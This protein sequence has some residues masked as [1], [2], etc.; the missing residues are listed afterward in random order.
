VQT[1]CAAKP[2]VV[3]VH[4]LAPFR[5]P[6]MFPAIY[7]DEYNPT[8]AVY[9]RAL[10]ASARRS[11]HL[12]L[13]ERRHPHR[14]VARP[15]STR[16]NRWA[17]VCEGAQTLVP[18]VSCMGC[19]S[20]VPRSPDRPD[21][22]DSAATD[23]LLTCRRPAPSRFAVPARGLIS[24]LVSR[25]RASDLSHAP[26][27]GAARLHIG[28]GDDYRN[29]FVNL[30]RGECRADVYHDLNHVPYPFD[31]HTFELIIAN[32]TLEHLSRESWVPIVVE[33]YRISR[34]NAVWEF[35]SPYALSD[36]FATDPTH[37]MALTPRTFDY[38]DPT[39]DLSRFGRIYGMDCDL[40][41][42]TGTLI[43]TDRH[44][45]DVYH[46][47]LVVKAEQVKPQVPPELPAFLY[48]PEPAL[49][50]LRQRMS[51]TRARLTQPTLGG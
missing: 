39:R 26:E 49:Q 48:Q 31:D 43:P 16:W 27:S 44:G 23:G 15:S 3:T 37:R 47:L 24:P 14:R 7:T 46:R 35:R 38:F 28:C 45:P 41:V 4:D 36:N 8:L 11:A 20:A 2:T 33:L 21:R 10:A 34:P 32:Q 40:R 5:L 6:E 9:R 50:R 17:A 25:M 19:A 30:D 1:A 13:C 18:W 29:G 22:K 42:L 12:P 51:I